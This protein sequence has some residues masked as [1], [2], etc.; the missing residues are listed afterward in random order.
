M[1]VYMFINNT[2][3]YITCVVIIILVM[4]SM[5]IKQVYNKAIL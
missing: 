1:Y 2:F 5:L 3:A 4:V